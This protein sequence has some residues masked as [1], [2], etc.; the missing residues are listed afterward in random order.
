M[1]GPRRRNTGQPGDR[2]RQ[3]QGGCGARIGVA[4]HEEMLYDQSGQPTTTSYPRY[5]LPEAEMSPAWTSPTCA[6]PLCT[7]GAR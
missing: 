2:R 5:L 4:L 3:V 1:G 6:L 7:S